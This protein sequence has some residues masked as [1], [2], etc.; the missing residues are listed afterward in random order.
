MDLFMDQILYGKVLVL[1]DYKKKIARTDFLILLVWICTYGTGT[2]KQ[3]NPGDLEI[4]KDVFVHKMWF[5]YPVRPG[6]C[7]L[8][9]VY[10]H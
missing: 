3:N 8:F 7:F 9:L 2:H 5:S 4:R 6:F 1:V 10:E